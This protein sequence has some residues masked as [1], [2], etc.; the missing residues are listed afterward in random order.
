MISTRSHALRGNAYILML[1]DYKGGTEFNFYREHPNVTR[2]E[3]QNSVE[4]GMGLLDEILDIKAQRDELFQQ[5][6]ANHIDLYNK[7]AEKRLHR[8]LIIIDEFH[9]LFQGDFKAKT[10]VNMMFGE[11]ARMGRSY[12]IHLLLCTQSLQDVELNKS[13]Y[14]QIGLRI[15]FKIDKSDWRKFV[16]STHPDHP[17]LKKL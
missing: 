4:N 1:I 2:L 10:K 9:K 6:N 14:A 13:I 11:I 16:D 5:V 12:G 15:V 7:T 3:I 17:D 8:I